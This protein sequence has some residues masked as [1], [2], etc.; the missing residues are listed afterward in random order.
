LVENR[1]GPG[2]RLGFALQLKHYQLY[3]R[4]L[5]GYREVAGDVAE[6]LVDQLEDDL[7]TLDAYNWGGRSGR[8]HRREILQFLRVRAFDAEA[9]TSLREW[10][11]NETL[12]IAPNLSQLE[13]LIKDWL[14]HN[15][16]DRP[17]NY[18]LDRL[19][20]SARRA[21]EERL[22][23]GVHAKLDSVAYARLDNLL[24]EQDGSTAF[25]RLR[26]DIG[27]A[28][29]ESVLKEID[30][31]SELQALALPKDLLSGLTP[32]LIDSYRQ[33]AAREGAWEL[34]RHPQRIRYPLLVFYCAPPPQIR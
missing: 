14:L 29:L 25:A 31:L 11:I 28:S 27:P 5:D 16:V 22:L 13:D 1:R 20:K 9:G 23:N 21:H 34:R 26:S 3:A 17:S 7:A 18:K 32:N 12:P 2:N 33:R 10:L 15:R 4:F 8:R 24:A 19:I 6:Y 30:K